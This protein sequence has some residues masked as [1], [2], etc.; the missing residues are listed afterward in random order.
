MSLTNV[1]MVLIQDGVFLTDCTRTVII[2]GAPQTLLL[3]TVI[4]VDCLSS[5]LALR[6][7][8]LSNV[9]NG[10]TRPFRNFLQLEDYTEYDSS[11]T[12]RI[13]TPTWKIGTL[14]A[15]ILSE[16]VV[17][18]IVAI[19]RVAALHS[20]LFTIAAIITLSTWVGNKSPKAYNHS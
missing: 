7:P 20:R 13:I 18:S 14:V 2:S 9:V 16:L 10:I 3:A 6:I 19:L 15:L 4:S 5:S 8:I 11:K 17:L 12:S 1:H